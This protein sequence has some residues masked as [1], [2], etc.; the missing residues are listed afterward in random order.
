M[1]ALDDDLLVLLSDVSC[2]MRTYADQLAHAHGMTRAQLIILARLQM[3]PDPTQNELAA[4]AELAPI[5]IA[6]CSRE[7]TLRS[8]PWPHW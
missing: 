6:R 7:L 1:P 8:Q 4:L 2:H 5:T 3:Q